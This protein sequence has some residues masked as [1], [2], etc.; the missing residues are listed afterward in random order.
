MH[1]VPAALALDIMF[2]SQFVFNLIRIMLL[3]C[4]NSCRLRWTNYLRPDIKLGQF[5]FEEEHTI[6][7]LHAILG[8]KWS[9]IAGHLPGRTDNEIKNFWNTHLKK[10]L[11]QMDGKAK[12]LMANK[13]KK[14]SNFNPLL[15]RIIDVH[16]VFQIAMYLYFAISCQ[17]DPYTEY[18]G[19]VLTS[20]L[21]NHLGIWQILLF[22]TSN[23][24]SAELFWKR[25]PVSGLPLRCNVTLLKSKDSSWKGGI[26]FGGMWRVN[27]LAKSE[28]PMS[29]VKF[30]KRE[31][32][33][34][35][36]SLL[37]FK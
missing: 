33:M 23:I 25:V 37:E 32:E 36:S 2:M 14:E 1:E 24:F 5:S 11:L 30:W 16:L 15:D 10:R 9:T 13:I 12:E 27:R 28:R 4:G 34:L 31:N 8:N 21:P 26:K 20:Q 6:I 7:E 18:I 3:R 22:Q 29:L 17:N 19:D 35:P